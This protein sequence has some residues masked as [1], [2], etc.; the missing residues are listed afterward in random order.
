MNRKTGAVRV[1][2]FVCA[3]DCGLIINP[4][5][6]RAT[7]AAN[8]MQSHEPRAEGRSHVRP[9]Q[10]DQRGLGQLSD[11]ARLG[12]SRASRYRA[13]QSS[14]TAVERRGRAFQPP[15]PA[16]I[17]N[18]IF[19]ATGARIR[20]ARSRPARVKAALAAQHA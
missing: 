17:A 15:T 11:R 9:Q 14:R 4:E 13:D 16:A 18:A 6:L 7:I 1:T 19:D 12:Y 3:H 5:A 10:R 8:L 20:Q 2:R